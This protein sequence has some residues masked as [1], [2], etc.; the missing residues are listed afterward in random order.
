MLATLAPMARLA[1]RA[2]REPGSI[3][4][5]QLLK[6]RYYEDLGRR[7]LASLGEMQVAL[8]RIEPE[9]STA[10]LHV[11]LDKLDASGVITRTTL[12]LAQRSSVWA[13]P[14]VELDDD[15][16]RHTEAFRALIYRSSGLDA[17]LT[18]AQLEALEGVTVE[19]VLKG[20][21]G[22]LWGPDV[23]LPPSIAATLEGHPDAIVA[24][25]SLDMAALDLAADRDN[26]PLDD[27]LGDKLSA[28]AQEAGY[29]TLRARCGYHAFR[30]RKLVA[31]DPAVV[32]GLRALCEAA[33]TR[34]IVYALRAP[35][36]GS[37]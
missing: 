25:F 20:T 26:D 6:R 30:D 22:P 34:N 12:D 19:R 14:L 15:D 21:V 37:A 18:W 33:G 29:G 10:H 35:H 5:R 9:A 11:V 17:E 13:R 31:S 1:A 23:A 16:A 4:A 2:A 36:G 3:H 7:R 24:S 8:R 32:P 28:A 27:L